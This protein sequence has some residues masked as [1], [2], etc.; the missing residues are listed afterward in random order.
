MALDFAVG[1]A[2]TAY[3]THVSST[4]N[5]A[6][7]GIPAAANPNII[8]TPLETGDEIGVFTPDGLCVGAVAWN[9][10]VS[11]AITVWGDD[12]QTPAVDGIKVGEQMHICVWRKS[13]KT[14]YGD[15]SVTYSLGEGS[16][17]VNGIY[18]LA[19]LTANAVVAPMAPKL[20]SPD[21]DATDVVR[22]P[23]LRWY[24]AC[25]ARFYA[26]QISESSTFSNLVVDESG[27][28]TTFYQVSALAASTTYYWRVKATNDVGTSDWSGIWSFTTGTT[29]GVDESPAE[30]SQTYRLYQNYPNPF[31][32]ST[33]TQFDLKQAG[34]VML[35]VYNSLGQEVA[36][37][38]DKNLPAGRHTVTFDATDLPSGVYFYRMSVNGFSEVKKMEV[39]K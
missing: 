34:Q 7:V 18:A 33:T 14:G 32:P 3:F 16:Y 36:T 29:V 25:S 10:G 13:T 26:V 39:I 20:A 1:L 30:I 27:I 31:N 15:V 24:T 11:A 8:G 5:N 17:A 28:D 37:L 2:Q 4:G 21:T 9:A 35:K 19:S 23:G 12:N 22:N 38:T 6:T